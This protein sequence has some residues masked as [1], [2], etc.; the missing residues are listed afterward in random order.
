MTGTGTPETP[1][2]TPS[3]STAARDWHLRPV[4]AFD[5]ETTGVDVTRDR[6]VTAAVLTRG[7]DVT[8]LPATATE[9]LIDPGIEIPAGAS[10]VHG[11]TTTYAREHGRTAP[12]AV[13]EIAEALATGI[14]AGLPVVAFN[15]PYDV[16]LLDAELSRHALVPLRERIGNAPLYVLDPL[17]LDRAL[18][19]FRR[20]KRTLTH[21]CEVYDVEVVE[22]LHAAAADAAVTVDVLAG[23]ARTYPEL[24]AMTLAELLEYQRIRHRQWSD[25]FNEWL[26]SQGRTHDLISPEWL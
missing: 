20:G 26:V 21:L 13:N 5:T 3:M 6:I 8:A 19:R 10:A 22:E 23:L 15:A 18:V 1:A 9:W 4:L 7:L 17:V 24:M 16:S 2:T 11:I 25:N 12:E 14:R